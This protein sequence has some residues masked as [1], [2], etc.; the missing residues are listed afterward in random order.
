MKKEKFCFA[1]TAL[2][3]REARAMAGKDYVPYKVAIERI[4]FLLANDSPVQDA[5]WEKGE[6]NV[7]PRLASQ[8][9]GWFGHV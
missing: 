6:G 2:T 9:D 8:E 3:A 7:I 1:G 5:S 4:A